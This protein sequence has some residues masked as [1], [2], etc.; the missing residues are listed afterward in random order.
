MASFDSWEIIEKMLRNKGV[1]PG[2]P[3]ATHIYRY[4]NKWN[5]GKTFAVYWDDNH[6]FGPSEFVIDPVLLMEHGV[7]TTEGEEELD[8]LH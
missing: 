7:L 2:D 1:Y 5:G 3:P 6:S 4:T 8:A